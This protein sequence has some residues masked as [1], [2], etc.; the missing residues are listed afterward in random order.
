MFL[1]N[2]ML[3]L[4]A[5]LIAF[6]ISTDD[7]FLSVTYSLANPA[8]SELKGYVIARTFAG[9]Q[10]LMTIFGWLIIDVI[11]HLWH[12]I[13]KA[14]PFLIF[15]FLLTIGVKLLL[16]GIFHHVNG[17]RVAYDFSLKNIFLHGLCSSLDALALG[18]TF[19]DESF[20]Y[21]LGSAATVSLMTFFRCHSG[22]KLGRKMNAKVPYSS[23]IVSGVIIISISIMIFIKRI[24]G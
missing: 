15:L 23:G 19:V 5:L 11:E 1:E 4:D 18:I 7:F 8:L 9:L 24:T 14:V 22:I 13:V 3:V 20:W 16:E 2:L 21:V 6:S 10:F 12:P 17:F